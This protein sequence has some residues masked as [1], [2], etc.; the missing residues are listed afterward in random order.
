[1]INQDFLNKL[2]QKPPFLYIDKII[3]LEPL[4]RAVALKLVSINDPNVIA[5]NSQL[6]YMP[7]SLILE[8]M[9]QTGS[10]LIL[11]SNENL[12][13]TMAFQGIKNTVFHRAV[14][15]GDALRIEMDILN[16]KDQSIEMNGL[17]TVDGKTICEGSFTFSLIKPLSRPQI[18]TT[19][20]VHASAVIGKDVSIGP[21]TIIGEHVIIGDNTSIDANC[22]IEKWSKI[23][24]GNKISFGTIIGSE[25]QDLKYSGEKT[26]VVIGDRNILREYVT[27]NRSTGE[28]TTTEIGS[29]CHFLTHVHVGHNSLIGNNVTIANTTNLA[30]HVHVENNVTIGGMTG[31]HQFTRIGEGSMVGAY[32]RLPQDIL[33]FMLCEG[34]PARIR[35]I[36]IIGVKRSGASLAEVKELKLIFKIIFQSELNTSQ[37]VDSID[38]LDLKFDRPK[39]V[40]AFLKKTSDRGF[41]KRS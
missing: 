14:Y 3:D 9:S 10:Y 6:P 40:L 11:K 25:A 32:T 21:N 20:S 2:T 8:S 27:I 35:A 36:N 34:N 26:W 16:I 17:C 39:K 5:N 18:H 22:F 30:G 1:M 38:A 7:P 23:G 33:P 31:V 12:G 29:D 4:K 24:E 19:A 15:P 37:A 41:I 28:N 13:K